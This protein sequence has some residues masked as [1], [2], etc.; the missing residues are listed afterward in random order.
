MNKK[1]MLILFAAIGFFVFSA[2][3]HAAP[4]G[5]PTAQTPSQKLSIGPLIDIYSQDFKANGYR[6]TGKG[7][8]LFLNF[9]YGVDRNV[10][11]F[12]NAGFSKEDLEFGGN[13]YSGNYGMGV[14]FGARA[15]LGEL[16]PEHIKF[17]GGAKL[18]LARSSVDFSPTLKSDVDWTEFGLFGGMSFESQSDMTPYLGLQI[19]KTASNIKDPP[20]GIQ[21]N[22]DEDGLI[23]LFGGLDLKIQKDI[24]IGM[25]LRILNEISAALNCNFSF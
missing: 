16:R 21:S 8:R 19:A 17:G 25:E 12:G 3:S 5:N 13:T 15:T 23:G 22:F 14:Q 9:N 11:F 6:I 7:N 20:A 18:L 24:S 4:I 1:M 2:E 10:N